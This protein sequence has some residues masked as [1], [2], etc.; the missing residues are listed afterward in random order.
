MTTPDLWPH[1]V[2]SLKKYEATP[3]IFDMSDPG[4]G[5]TRAAIEAYVKLGKTNASLP[6]GTKPEDMTLEKA[7]KLIEEKRAS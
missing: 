7:L 5:K 2:K 3:H 4:T 6:K 1:Q